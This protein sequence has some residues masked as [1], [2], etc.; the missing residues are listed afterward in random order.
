MASLGRLNEGKN[1]AGG[2][3]MYS[4][5]SVGATYAFTITG[6]AGATCSIT[7]AGA[8]QDEDK[9]GA[10]SSVTR[11]G[12]A[13]VASSAGATH[14]ITGACAV[15]TTGT[16]GS[17]TLSRFVTIGG[18][19]HTFVHGC[20]SGRGTDRGKYLVISLRANVGH[21][22]VVTMMGGGSHRHSC[23]QLFVSPKSSTSPVRLRHAKH[24][25]TW[26][27]SRATSAMDVASLGLNKRTEN[28]RL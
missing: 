24:P 17:S 16:E 7:D 5:T 3:A 18:V 28:K 21:G 9:T 20:R 22:L 1:P 15:W 25:T 19:C 27:A 23:R 6:V 10:T 8:A 13:R 4:F 14:S 11:A 26:W 2:G 12:V